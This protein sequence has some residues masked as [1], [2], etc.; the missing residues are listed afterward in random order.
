MIEMM[1]LGMSPPV[2]AI[3][4]FLDDV[5]VS[6]FDWDS[7][8]HMISTS[9]SYTL[10][11]TDTASDFLT[12]MSESE[13]VSIMKPTDSKSD[14]SAYSMTTPSMDSKSS[15]D[16]ST[17]ISLPVPFTVSDSAPGSRSDS[18]DF[19][20]DTD[21]DTDTDRIATFTLYT[22]S[23]TDV[24][25]DTD[26]SWEGQ[27]RDLK[28][29]PGWFT[30]ADSDQNTNPTEQL[31]FYADSGSSFESSSVT[32]G[33]DVDLSMSSTDHHVPSPTRDSSNAVDDT[34]TSLDDT[35]SPSEIN[36]LC[37][38]RKQRDSVSENGLINNLRKWWRGGTSG[39]DDI[40]CPTM[41]TAST[42]ISPASSAT[43]Y[44]VQTSTQ[45]A[46][47]TPSPRNADWF[48]DGHDSYGSSAL[49]DLLSA[50]SL[51]D[52]DLDSTLGDIDSSGED[53]DLS[54]SSTDHHVPS[55]TRGSSNAVDDT[56]TSLDDTPSQDISSPHDM[57]LSTGAH[58]DD[59]SPHLD[60]DMGEFSS[61]S[62]PAASASPAPSYAA[63]SILD[64]RRLRKKSNNTSPGPSKSETLVSQKE[65]SE[66]PEVESADDFTGESSRTRGEVESQA[67][68]VYAIFVGVGVLLGCACCV[69]FF[70]C[71]RIEEEDE[72]EA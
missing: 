17:T 25:S 50:D 26:G 29:L 12:A 8:T 49:E 44:T 31:E 21:W 18:P 55:A 52:T 69:R 38:N 66:H 59:W 71:K 67:S 48:S 16:D 3:P 58:I 68:P 41:S 24:T 23:S 64:K 51:T 20:S 13:T 61:T 27:E 57:S 62:S 65:E 1:G 35:P 10:A 42:D 5:L 30:Y 19:S 28:S 34:D 7:Q 4:H 54:M 56:D 53:V 40:G 63:P 45:H 15:L 33:E 60:D 9:A 36:P 11:S 22:L 47:S 6:E 70:F 39:D 14:S 32:S 43:T 72:L 2:R 37:N 46:I